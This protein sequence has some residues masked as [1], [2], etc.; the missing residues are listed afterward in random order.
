MR[1]FLE[2]SCPLRFEALRDM[3][4][5][6]ARLLLMAPLCCGYPSFP[7]LEAARNDSFLTI[8]G[9]IWD[10]GRGRCGVGVDEGSCVP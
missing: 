1:R 4:S 2:F 5:L 9:C 6:L 8:K 3:A 7:R 10:K